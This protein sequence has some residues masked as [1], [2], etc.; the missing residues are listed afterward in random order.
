MQIN[1]G[2]PLPWNVRDEEGKL[3]LA[4]GYLISTVTMLQN[5]LRRGVFVDA[6]EVAASQEDATPMLF[7]ERRRQQALPFAEQW[8]ILE[9]RLTDLLKNYRDPEFLDGIGDLESMIRN[10]TEKHSDQMIYSVIRHDKERFDTYGITHSIHV[11]SVCSILANRLQWSKTQRTCLISA[12][13]TMNLSMIEL[14]GHLAQV[15]TEVSR[16]QR[17][18]IREHPMESAR[19]LREAGL[20]DIDWLTAVEQHHEKPDG[21]GYPHGQKDKLSEISQMIRFADI[22][23]AK[24]SARKNRKPV[25]AK[26]AAQSV[27]LASGGHPIASALLKEFGIYPPGCFVALESGETA[28]IVRRG[29]TATSPLVAVLRNKD[30][31]QIKEMLLRETGMP[32][33]AIADTIQDPALPMEVAMDRLFTLTAD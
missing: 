7:L 13:L 3:L 29:K 12:A 4:R 33:Y 14:Q 20:T 10:A 32:R 28:I 16:E 2:A 30:G 11:A 24:Y 27:Y 17:A 22:F 19:I 21:S 25:P 1:C 6:D 23:T 18:A 15:G 31:V 5:L 8:Q 26:Q 9:T